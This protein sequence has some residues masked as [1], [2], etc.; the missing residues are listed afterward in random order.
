MLAAVLLGTGAYGVGFLFDFV[1]VKRVTGVK[2]MV[3]VLFLALHGLALAVAVFSPQRFPLPAW[4]VGAGYV[5]LPLFAAL[6]A[7]SLFF[8]L[9]TKKTYA[10][11]GSSNQL[12]TTGTYALTRHP[13]VLWYTFGM[14]ALTMATRST[15]LLIAAPLWV[16]LDVLHVVVQDRV[17]FPKMFSDYPQYQRTTPMLIPTLQ[18]IEAC[19]KT[20]RRRNLPS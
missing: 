16:F 4:A 8:E 3:A 12:V 15:A 9:P 6:L 17:F 14:V 5:T 11:A 7:Y 2:A 10:E 19:V 20:V 13:G 18:S 1:A